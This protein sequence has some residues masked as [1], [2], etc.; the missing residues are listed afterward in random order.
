LLGGLLRDHARRPG[1]QRPAPAVLLPRRLRLS[2][3][4]H[5]A[6]ELAGQALSSAPRSVRRQPVQCRRWGGGTREKSPT[7]RCGDPAREEEI[8][9]RAKRNAAHFSGV[10]LV[11][12]YHAG[13]V[14]R[15]CLPSLCLPVRRPVMDRRAGRQF[16]APPAKNKIIQ[17]VFI[18]P[19]KAE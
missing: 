9:V 1:G 7:P 15:E 2:A 19:V 8:S 12:G 16:S 14:R 10:L 4:P 5:P 13:D 3:W 6:A 17:P 11:A 18:Y